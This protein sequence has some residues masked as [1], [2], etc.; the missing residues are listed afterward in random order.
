M[1]TARETIR[2]R[3][4][5]NVELV[6]H[7]GRKVRFYDDLVQGRT[8]TINFMY[9]AC[10]DGTCP[11]T[12]HNLA[13]IQ[14]ILGRS[15]GRELFMYSITLNPE[16]DTPQHLAAYA[17]HFGAGPGWS[18]LQASPEDTERLRRALGFYE[19]DPEADKVKSNH[20]AMIRYGNEPR[21]LWASTRGL[22]DP[23]VAAHSIRWVM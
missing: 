21:T 4:L 23:E 2:R 6:T 11:M 3:H 12:T 1:P 20:A 22:I 14:R 7:R 13:Q 10:S 19:T 8:V 5:P 17:K 18:F 9:I 15:V 16:Y